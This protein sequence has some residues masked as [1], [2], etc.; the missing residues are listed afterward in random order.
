MDKNEFRLFFLGQAREES[1]APRSLVVRLA[2]FTVFVGAPAFLFAEF[3]EGQVV[4]GWQGEGG[5]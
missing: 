4:V 3:G 2:R 5:R 1:F